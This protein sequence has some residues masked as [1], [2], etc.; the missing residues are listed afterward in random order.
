MSKHECTDAAFLYQNYAPEFELV[1]NI[2]RQATLVLDEPAM[3]PGPSRLEQ[4]RDDGAHR[5]TSAEFRKMVEG[6]F[7]LQESMDETDYVDPGTVR[8][9]I[10]ADHHDLREQG[11]FSPSLQENP[12]G[13]LPIFGLQTTLSEFTDTGKE[14]K[15]AFLDLADGRFSHYYHVLSRTPASPNDTELNLSNYMEIHVPV[16]EYGAAFSLQRAEAAYHTMR[17]PSCE[18]KARLHQLTEPHIDVL[19]EHVTWFRHLRNYDLD[20][21]T[22]H[23]YGLAMAQSVYEGDLSNLQAT[24]W[25]TAE[26]VPGFET[27][28]DLWTAIRKAKLVDQFTRYLTFGNLAPSNNINAFIP[29][30]VQPDPV[31]GVRLN[32]DIVSDLKRY[33]LRVLK[34][35]AKS[36]REYGKDSAHVSENEMGI[37]CPAVMPGAGLERRHTILFNRFVKVQDLA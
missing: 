23:P 8:K 14:A 6:P 21:I 13:R 3:Q 36:I 37:F 10:F 16:G 33:K 34:S 15:K 28:K 26:Y 19:Q 1:S 30:L 12:M 18:Q 27:G 25:L 31:R 20:D 11:V 29:D 17:T 5:K 22:N 9:Q 7:A 4:H 24:S 35:L 32:P 2:T